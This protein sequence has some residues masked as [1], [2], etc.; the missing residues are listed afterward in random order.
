MFLWFED[1]DK[2]K[3]N[4]GKWSQN[5]EKEKYFNLSTGA[6]VWYVYT[7]ISIVNYL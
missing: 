5:S 6:H 4:D 2:N 7:W 1:D 3:Y